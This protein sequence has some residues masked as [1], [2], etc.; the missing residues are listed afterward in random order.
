MSERNRRNTRD[1]ESEIEDLFSDTD[2]I[3][4]GRTLEDTL[5][6]SVLSDTAPLP[7]AAA[8]ED[9]LPLET[10]SDTQP[11]GELPEDTMP[12]SELPEDTLPIDELPEDTLPLGTLE[13]TLPM[14]GLEDIEDTKAPEDT[15]PLETLSLDVDE[16]VF[17]DAAE[18]GGGSRSG[19]E[20]EVFHI[21]EEESA[22]E[23]EVRP[24]LFHRDTS[25][26]FDAQRM[27]SLLDAAILLSAIAVVCVGVLFGMRFVRT[28]NIEAERRTFTE[29]GVQLNGVAMIGGDAIRA[30]ADERTAQDKA[31]A[32]KALE[33]QKARE[34]AE[35]K[36]REGSIGIEM[37]LSSVLSDIKV[38]F[39]LKEQQTILAGKPFRIEITSPDGKSTVY[40]DHDRDGVIY[41]DK[42]SA[43]TYKVRVLPFEDSEI[44]QD[45]KL[46]EYAL[47]QDEK[48]VTVTDELAY[49]KIDIAGEVK[50]ESE[51]NVAQEDTAKKDTVVESV[52]TDT[53]TWV[54]STK[55]EVSEGQGGV[56]TQETAYEKVTKDEIPNPYN[57]ASAGVDGA[58]RRLAGRTGIGRAILRTQQDVESREG[59]EEGAAA[60]ASE[61]SGEKTEN[62]AEDEGEQESSSGQ[63][64]KKEE[65]AGATQEEQ[66][67]EQQ[68]EKKEEQK[69]EPK[70]EQQ[71]EQKEEQKEEQPAE[72]KKEE[73]SIS[74]PY[75]EV[76]LSE[77]QDDVPLPKVTIT[78]TDDTDCTWEVTEGAGIV[79]VEEGL[80]KIRKVGTALLTVTSDA[81][82]TKKAELKVTVNEKKR[83][84]RLES[85]P[86]S[87]TIQVGKTAKI[88]PSV[89][90]SE[91]TS[92]DYE[93]D[94]EDIAEVSSDG[95]VTGIAKGE[96]EIYVTANADEDV[97][98][99][100]RVTVQTAVDETARLKDAEGNP[101]YIRRSDGTY[102]EAIVADYNH[103]DVFYRRAS[104]TKQYKYTGWQTIEGN[105]YYFNSDG[106][107]V[108]GEQTIQGA[109]YTFNSD[110][111]L[112]TGNTLTG[113]DVS[114]WNG[115][116]DW[117]AVRNSGISYA[118]IRCGYRGSSVGA[119]IEDS[120]FRANMAGAA[121]AGLKVGV[122]FF[123]QAVNEVEAVEEATYVLDTIAGYSLSFPVFLD[124]ES[125]GGRG[126]AISVEQRTKNIVA[127]C[128]T[129]SAYGYSAGIYAN[130]N[131]LNE[132]INAGSLT[133]YH[134]WLAQY[135][136][137][138]TYTRTRYDL[139]QYSSTGRV[140][141]ISGN[142]DMNISYRNY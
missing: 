126:D 70:E 10:I 27:F 131:W 92:V 71:E 100:V 93:S 90:G 102:A 115:N 6:M 44:T 109:K 135:A 132:K 74:I 78:G 53:V 129:I 73:V 62:K 134:I 4:E 112:A 116:I 95:T 133:N 12:I 128:K 16:S 20:I 121:N 97:H 51:V 89:T 55:T 46:R 60:E 47:P 54:E 105:T 113:I 86:D 139:W 38:K 48:T 96:T 107:Y 140:S 28:R 13:D 122:Y 9:T 64:E 29:V 43:G 61:E 49:K 42:L 85:V 123:S 36:A 3:T 120:K 69:E 63:E 75:G 87:L 99:T 24:G 68:E 1:T 118:I 142:V 84:V 82:N 31:R 19:E 57:T 33:E 8:L 136:A 65:S 72:E 30:L 104:T 101:L 40:D 83:E 94:D 98:K 80:I 91:D 67:E 50:K 37:T 41:K 76:T 45:K 18:S 22:P 124:V 81:D 14:G 130:V 32:E 58:F 15:V 56:E 114:T 25:G 141:G 108:T 17:D 125:S 5:P 138:P 52:N 106:T 117:A 66:K 137:V 26:V 103:Y 2:V 77:D 7:K 21:D 111:V 23:R 119:I 39:L 79:V 34:E 88:N 35:E 59:G 11:I 110:G 127:F